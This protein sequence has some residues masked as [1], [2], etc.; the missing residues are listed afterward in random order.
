MAQ[1]RGEMDVRTALGALRRVVRR[2]VV[3]QGLRLVLAGVAF[4][5]PASL[6]ASRLLKGMLNHR[7]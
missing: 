1:P 6:A 2:M 4:G 5:V 3:G 7:E